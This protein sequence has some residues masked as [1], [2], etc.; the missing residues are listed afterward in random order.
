LGHLSFAVD[1]LKLVIQDENEP[2][3]CSHVR[4]EF[5]FRRL[6]TSWTLNIRNEVVVHA[7]NAA[8]RAS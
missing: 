2:L 6:M 4:L 5:D 7:L 1:S 3:Q 8:I